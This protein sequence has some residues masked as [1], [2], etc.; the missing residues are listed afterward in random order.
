MQAE[1]SREAQRG[2]LLAFDQICASFGVLAMPK[3]V[4]NRPHAP[5][6]A[7]ARFD[8][9]DIGVPLLERLRC[10][11]TSQSGAGH[12]DF[13]MVETGHPS[14]VDPLYGRLLRATIR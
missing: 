11:E 8:Q 12:E 3:A 13:D 7:V 6:N 5:A 4:T 2:F 10:G 1:R 9:G 14:M